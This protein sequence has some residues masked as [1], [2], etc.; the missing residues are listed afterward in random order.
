[1]RGM[2]I[3]KIL[4]LT[5]PGRTTRSKKVKLYAEVLAKLNDTQLLECL[6]DC[7]YSRGA[8][9]ADGYPCNF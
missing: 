4:E 6:V 5:Y 7:A 2:M 9:E 3:I 8:S 1:M